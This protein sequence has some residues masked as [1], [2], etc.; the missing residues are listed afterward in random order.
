MGSTVSVLRHASIWIGTTVGIL[1]AGLT[2]AHADDTTKPRTPNLTDT[3]ILKLAVPVTTPGPGP[4]ASPAIPSPTDDAAAN[5]NK[6]SGQP[7]AAA[8]GDQ[9]IAVPMEMATWSGTET[10]GLDAWSAYGGVAYALSGRLSDPGWRVRFSSGQS[11]FA[12]A[13]TIW[14][15][16]PL[17][18]RDPT[19]YDVVRNGTVSFADVMLGYQFREGDW[20]I[21]LLGGVAW[22]SR[23]YDLAVGLNQDDLG[24]RWGAKLAVET[25]RNLGIDGHFVQADASYAIGLGSYRVETRIGG[26]VIPAWGLQAGIEAASFGDTSSNAYRGGGFVRAPLLGR[27]VTIS[28]G[29]ALT[30]DEL[31][32]STLREGLELSSDDVDYYAEIRSFHPF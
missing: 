28:G 2:A 29:A 30:D 19:G 22:E 8:Q 18:G 27:T 14:V 21:K 12:S 26:P 3:G 10:N 31:N 6:P 24:E 16:S 25:W 15:A 13:D 1:A 17:P 5:A 4:S 32:A 11:Q 9:G 7:G 20:T 23:S